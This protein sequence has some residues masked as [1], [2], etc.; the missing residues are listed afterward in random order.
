MHWQWMYGQVRSS[1]QESISKAAAFLK[2]SLC[3]FPTDLII[4][5]AKSAELDPDE[6][7]RLKLEELGVPLPADTISEDAAPVK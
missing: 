5:A 2:R 4:S 1:G 6:F 7:A 3:V